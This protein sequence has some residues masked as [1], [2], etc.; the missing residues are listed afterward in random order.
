M[1]STAEYLEACRFYESVVCR[2]RVG[3]ASEAE[4]SDAKYLKEALYAE[5]VS[6]LHRVV[7]RKRRVRCVDDD[8]KV[9]RRKETQRRYRE[10][11][12]I[13]TNL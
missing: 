9:A 6:D 5:L 3:D 2:Y 10:K 7:S 8:D 4:V 11:K 12:K 13:S 1:I